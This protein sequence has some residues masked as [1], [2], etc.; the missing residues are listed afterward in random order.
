[1]NWFF[2]DDKFVYDSKIVD[3]FGTR[4]HTEKKKTRVD[5]DM[6]E[7]PICIGD[8]NFDPNAPVPEQIDVLATFESGAF[9]LRWWVDVLRVETHR[10]L[11]ELHH[12]DG[13]PTEKLPWWCQTGSGR[14]YTYDAFERLNAAHLD[15]QRR[16]RKVK[17][18]S[19]KLPDLAVAW[20]QRKRYGLMRVVSGGTGEPS[21]E[22]EPFCRSVHQWLLMQPT[23]GLKCFHATRLSTSDDA[24][25][26]PLW[27]FVRGL[28]V[29]DTNS[30]PLA[31]WFMCKHG[32]LVGLLTAPVVSLTE[33][34]RITGWHLYWDHLFAA[35]VDFIPQMPMSQTRWI[36]W[37]WK[38][39]LVETDM[40][41]VQKRLF[42]PQ[43]VWALESLRVWCTQWQRSG[44]EFLGWQVSEWPAVMA[45]IHWLAQHH[46]DQWPVSCARLL[47]SYLM[48]A[49]SIGS[50]F[51][52]CVARPPVSWLYTRTPDTPPVLTGTLA[53][54]PL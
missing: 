49:P 9:D 47:A 43:H 25:A 33:P 37:L 18:V 4:I 35:W 3:A 53:S 27:Q 44:L 11:D 13:Q 45:A 19:W 8:P 10:F 16:S 20:R 21:A 46:R 17:C 32:V 23:L 1:M 40:D 12:T 52:P 15:R 14:F 38:H 6:E 29:V 28:F 31:C 54:E 48:R 7:E 2:G 51:D 22:W 39:H 36:Q 41:A 24:R 26:A 30:P 50:P 5:L 42:L 34:M